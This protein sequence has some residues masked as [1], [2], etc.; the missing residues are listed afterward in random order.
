MA[1][2]SLPALMF[3]CALGFAQ[4]ALA[5]TYRTTCSFNNKREACTINN[6]S[7]GNGNVANFFVTWLSDGKQTYY[8]VSKDNV[9]IVE[10]NRRTSMGRWYRENGKIVINSSGGNTTVLPW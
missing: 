1:T 3:V 6:W 7:N 8:A 5:Q 2:R 9:V 10:D 4:V